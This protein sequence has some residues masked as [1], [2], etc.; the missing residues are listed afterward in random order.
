VVSSS[1]RKEKL[2]QTIRS[3]TIFGVGRELLSHS[4]RVSVDFLEKTIIVQ[5]HQ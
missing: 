3:F 5:V 1:S 2:N 4:R